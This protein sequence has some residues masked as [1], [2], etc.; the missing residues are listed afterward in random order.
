[1]TQAVNAQTQSVSNNSSH[2]ELSPRTRKYLKVAFN[3][4]AG[5][6]AAA[7]AKVAAV[8]LIGLTWTAAPALAVI[9]LSSLAVG[10][11]VASTQYMLARHEAKKQNQALPKFF[12]K[13]NLKQFGISSALAFAGGLVF[14]GYDQLFTAKQVAAETVVKAVP[15][16]AACPPAT[17]QFAEAVAGA[18][19]STAV[20]S[21]IE[22]AQSSVAEVAAQAK[23]DLAYFTFNG[24]GGVAE[25]KQLALQ[26]FK[27]AAEAGNVQAKVD[28]LYIQHHGLAGVAADAKASTAMMSTLETAKAQAFTEAWTKAAGAPTQAVTAVPFST[29]AVFKGAVLCK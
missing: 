29:E 10:A 21:A 2:H 12:S 25:N 26:L 15:V 24:L 19:L 20:E 22:R 11:A 27:D 9:M 4:A 28:L 6:V 8:T 5:F 18:K 17:A 3:V 23:K 7:S 13:E 14:F 16:E 1:M